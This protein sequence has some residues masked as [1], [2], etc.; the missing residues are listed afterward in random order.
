MVNPSL[1]MMRMAALPLPTVRPVVPLG[2]SCAGALTATNGPL[3]ALA[4]PAVGRTMPPGR[5]PGM[6]ASMLLSLKVAE[7]DSPVRERRCRW[8][9]VPIAAS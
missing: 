4:P 6:E 9:V 8:N 5:M 1:A 2:T 3:V 7:D